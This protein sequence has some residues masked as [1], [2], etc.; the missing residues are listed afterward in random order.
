MEAKASLY[1]KSWKRCR[2][3]NQLDELVRNSFLR[4]YLQETQG[5][6]DVAVIGG[7]QGHEIPVHGEVHTISGGFSGGGCTTSQQKR[8]ARTVMSVEAQEAD[9]ALDVDLVFTKADLRDVVPHDNDLV[10]ISVVT[11]GR[12]VHRVLVDQGSSAD[13][14]FWMTFNKLQLSPDLLRPYTG[15]L[16][17]FVGDQVEVLGHLELRTTFIDGTTSRTENIRYLVINAPFAYNILLG[18]PTLNRLRAVSLTMH[19]KMKLPGLG[20]KLITIKSDQ[21]EAKR[22]YENN[23]KTKRGVFMVTTRA[24]SEEGVANQR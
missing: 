5:V 7:D 17:G 21:K 9:D 24:P 11:V 14:M 1:N 6:A 3:S 22:C 20:G 10:V 16:Y 2:L 18:R 15:C 19:M 23:L 13:V 4:D 12:K 8:Y